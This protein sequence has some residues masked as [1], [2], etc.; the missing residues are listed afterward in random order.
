MDLEGL[1]GVSIC[2]FL[3]ALVTFLP[4]ATSDAAI[5]L[6]PLNAVLGGLGFLV[7]LA[8]TVADATVKSLKKEN[9]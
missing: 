6:V 3:L 4:A 7:W 5:I 1:K 2:I 8:A 9:T